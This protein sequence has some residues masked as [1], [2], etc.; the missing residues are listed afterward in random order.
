MLHRDIS[1]NTLAYCR[2]ADDRVEGVLYDFDLAM[3]VDANTP[4]SKHRAG[5]TAFLVLHLLEDRTLQH[6]LVFEYE[7]LFYVMSW[8][9]AYHKRGG[10]AIE[11]NPFGRWYLGTADSIC[12]AKFGALRSPLDTLPHHKV[13]EDG[14]WRLQRL[15]RDAVFRMDDAGRSLRHPN[16]DYELLPNRGLNDE[17]LGLT[18]DGFSRVLQWGDEI[19][20][21]ERD[22]VGVRR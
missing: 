2:G 21:Y 11:G 18:A 22:R 8:I 17:V 13:L 9:I 1:I 19:E 3:Y 5:T 16:M 10:A 12:A 6:R 15:V 7:S 20:I 14:L 4:S